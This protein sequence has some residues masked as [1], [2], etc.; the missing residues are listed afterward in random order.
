[1]CCLLLRWSARLVG[2]DG[3]AGQRRH[4]EQTVAAPPARP[5]LLLRALDLRAAA[6]GDDRVARGHRALL[7]ALADRAVLEGLLG[8]LAVAGAADGLL[9]ARDRAPDIG[10]HV[11]V[12]EQLLDVGAKS[13]GCDGHRPRGP[14]SELPS[15]GTASPVG[16]NDT[17]RTM[18]DSVPG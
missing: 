18:W 9:G 11:V 3:P 5:R 16:A 8:V 14:G 6:D 4:A 2:G 17:I 15:G 1:M 7:R 10:L 13:L 12:V